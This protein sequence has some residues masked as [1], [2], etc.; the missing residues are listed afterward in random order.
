MV[1]S[2]QWVIQYEKCSKHRINI[3]T[4]NNINLHP[5]DSVVPIEVNRDYNVTVNYN[6]C[7]SERNITRINIT[8]WIHLNDDVF[9]HVPYIMC[10]LF[11]LGDDGTQIHLHSEKVF[12]QVNSDINCPVS[13]ET[14]VNATTT[15]TTNASYSM[16]YRTYQNSILFAL[17][18]LILMFEYYT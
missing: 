8:L 6:D 7:R 11:G 17:L 4:K 15:Y 10:T 14:T 16:Q 2:L 13:T 12:I 1:I 18:C 3:E 5:P 9:Q